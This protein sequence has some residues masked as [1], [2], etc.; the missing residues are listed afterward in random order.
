MKEKGLKELTIE[1]QKKLQIE[2]MKVVDTFCRTHK[3]TY[4]LAFGT[5]LGAIRHK[6]YIPWDDDLDIM[7][8][9]KDYN[10]LAN[11]F[12]KDGR[13]RFL[14]PDNTKNFPYAYGKIVDTYTIKNEAIWPKYQVIGLDVDVFPIDNYP[15]DIEEAKRWSAEIAKTQ[16]LLEKQFARFAKGRNLARTIVKNVLIAIRHFLDDINVCSVNHITRRIDKLS[17]KYNAEK[18]SYC[19]IVAI[20]TY[21]VRK[22]NRKQVFDSATEV[23]F[24]KERFFAPIGYDEYLTDIYGDYMQLPPPEKRITHHS[25]KAYWK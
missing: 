9:R 25:F 24:E 20:N 12:P 22:R 19:G 14:I 10:E 18:T 13:Y 16:S 1:E 15:D 7:M 4:Y 23:S 21:G 5:L 2:I 17:Q 11:I 8:P 6:G 3:L